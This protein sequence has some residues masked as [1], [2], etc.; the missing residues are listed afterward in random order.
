MKHFYTDWED[1]KSDQMCNSWI[2]AAIG[3]SALVGGLTS[4]YGANKA[5]S[6]QTSAANTAAGTQMQMYGQTRSDL[7]PYRDI[8][9]VASGQ[10]TNRLSELTSPVS[11][12]PDDF[13]NSQAYNFLWNQAERANNNS[14][15]ARGLGV[16]G[17][18]LKGASAFGSG[19]ASQ[20]W[21]QNFN[22]Q[23][24]NQT[25]AYNRL[26]GLV[27]TGA[28]AAAGTGQLGQ[29]AAAGAASAQIGAG[30]AQ[31]AGYNAL[32]PAVTNAG[33]GAALAGYG[34]YK[35]LYGSGNNEPA[36]GSPGGLPTQ[37]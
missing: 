26:K 15:A 4:L 25:N 5:A 16:S 8:G 35:G 14:A 9:G 23:V 33:T 1:F 30:N 7:S 28:N 6:A 11:V 18:A 19:L 12:N 29:Q 22:N 37:A 36:T 34:L 32:G 2:A 21:Q 20:F 17:A 3:G 13:K 10:L 24:T 31:A 27:D